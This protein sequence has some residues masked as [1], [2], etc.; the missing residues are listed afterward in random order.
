[1]DTIRVFVWPNDEW[2]FE[3]DL[4]DMLRW[5]SDDYFEAR[6]PADLFDGELDEEVV[7]YNFAYCF[8]R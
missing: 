1:M 3:E 2:C 4:E 8:R 5:L 7:V 6:I